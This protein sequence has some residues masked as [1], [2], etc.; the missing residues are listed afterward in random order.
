MERESKWVRKKRERE[1]D[2]GLGGERL[3]FSQ[4]RS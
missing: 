2:G 1:R 3:P 4:L